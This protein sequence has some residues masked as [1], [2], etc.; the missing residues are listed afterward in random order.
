MSRIRSLILSLSSLLVLTACGYSFVL[1][2]GGTLE[3]VRLAPS[4]N[5]T[6]LRE[7]G[8]TMDASLETQLSMMVLDETGQGDPELLCHIVKATSSEITS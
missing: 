7:A 4:L 5:Q 1:D 6:A 3:G 8:I 2:G